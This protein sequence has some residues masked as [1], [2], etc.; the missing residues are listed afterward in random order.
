MCL[1]E[2]LTVGKCSCRKMQLSENLPSENMCR[3]ICRRKNCVGKFA[4]GKFAVGKTSGYH[5]SYSL[6]L[7]NQVG[8]GI[9]IFYSDFITASILECIT[10]SSG[11]FESLFFQ[12]RIYRLFIPTTTTIIHKKCKSTFYHMIN[13]STNEYM[14]I[15]MSSRY[16][17]LYIYKHLYIH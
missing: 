6:Y 7:Q 14:S 5:K 9:K 2:N 12:K 8:G 15:D 1:S 13:I 4:V 10:S 11:A 3:K 17:Y 16:M